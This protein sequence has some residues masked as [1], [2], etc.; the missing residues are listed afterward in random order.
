MTGLNTVQSKG[1]KNIP[2]L[3]R[4]SQT[5]LT[6]LPRRTH[7]PCRHHCLPG[8]VHFCRQRAKFSESMKNILT[9]DLHPQQVD[10]K[11][12]ERRVLILKDMNKSIRHFSTLRPETRLR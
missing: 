6:Q 1:S 9:V 10:V 3:G 7:L 11:R 5:S 2:K 4:R 12:S 8:F